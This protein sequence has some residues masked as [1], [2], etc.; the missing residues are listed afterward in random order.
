MA[1]VDDEI[2][3]LSADMEQVRQDLKTLTTA[4]Q[5]AGIEKGRATLDRAKRE[6]EGLRERADREIEE[7]PLTSLLT[8]FGVGLLAGL[9][10]ER[11]R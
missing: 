10:M 8:S 7:R 4:F 11:R 1:S 5:E 2:K 9:V 3:K 6:A